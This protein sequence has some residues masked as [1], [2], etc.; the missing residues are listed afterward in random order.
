MTKNKL[1][2]WKLVYKDI[3]YNFLSGFLIEC[4]VG[5]GETEQRKDGK[6]LRR[7]TPGTE[8]FWDEIKDCRN[9]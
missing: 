4:S 5:S 1:F 2:E 3:N 7:R 8:N 6:L 9:C